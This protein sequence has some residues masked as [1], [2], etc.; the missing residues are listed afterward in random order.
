MVSRC[1][2]DEEMMTAMLSALT[3]LSET[4]TQADLIFTCLEKMIQSS[5]YSK[6][7]IQK[8]VGILVKLKVNQNL[9]Q[10]AIVAFFFQK[11]CFS[12]YCSFLLESKGKENEI[13]AN[14]A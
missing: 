1:E 8:A 14:L 2:D 7:T 6:A 10:Q 4:G 5:I 13:K 11:K 3:H 9:Q 12:E